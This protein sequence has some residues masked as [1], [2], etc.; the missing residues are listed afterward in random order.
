[1]TPDGVITTVAGGGPA[2]GDGGMAVAAAISV[3]GVALEEL[4]VMAEL[5]ASVTCRNP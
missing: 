2:M 1:M 4:P 5:R 3:A